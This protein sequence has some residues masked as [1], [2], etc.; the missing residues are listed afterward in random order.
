MTA[1]Y[2]LGR[3]NLVPGSATIKEAPFV[4][5]DTTLPVEI[6]LANIICKIQSSKS[7]QAFKPQKLYCGDNS[8]INSISAQIY[9]VERLKCGRNIYGRRPDTRFNGRISSRSS[10]SAF[11]SKNFNIMNINK[12]SA[13]ALHVL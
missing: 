8:I 13:K 5:P 10:H 1:Y 2:P 9:L 11:Q 4:V 12:T 7:L 6:I 3:L